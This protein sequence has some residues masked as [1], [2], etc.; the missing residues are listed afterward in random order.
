MDIYDGAPWTE[1]DIE[2][3]K[4]A[5]AH[6]ITVQDAAQ[7]LCR[8]GTVEEVARKCRELTVRN[9]RMTS[10]PKRPRDPN[11]LAFALG[12]SPASGVPNAWM[13]ER[14]SPWP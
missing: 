14:T 10:H 5:I 11:N 9:A 4:D 12:W 8:S 6:G 2:D 13:P 7:F 3:L 1:M